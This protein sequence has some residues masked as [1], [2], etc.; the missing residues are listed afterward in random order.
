MRRLLQ[1]RIEAANRCLTASQ[2]PTNAG[3]H[4]HAATF[5]Y[6]VVAKISIRLPCLN[7]LSIVLPHRLCRLDALLL[8]VKC[9]SVV[10]SDYYDARNSFSWTYSSFIHVNYLDLQGEIDDLEL[11]NEVLEEQGKCV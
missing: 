9:M 6:L 5:P 3:L 11:K 7:L 8:A 2:D 4:A 1:D 10:S